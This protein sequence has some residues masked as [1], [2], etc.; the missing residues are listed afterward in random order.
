MALVACPDCAR[1]VSDAA[2]VCPG[3]GRPMREAGPREQTVKLNIWQNPNGGAIG[4]L[5][6]VAVA[7]PILFLLYAMR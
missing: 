5:V 4:C 3:C 1:E 6:L 2:P 7:A